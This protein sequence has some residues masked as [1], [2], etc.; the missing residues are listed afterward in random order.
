MVG[1]NLIRWH[2]SGVNTST[3]VVMQPVDVKT[4]AAAVVV[5]LL[6]KFVVPC[7][8]ALAPEAWSLLAIFVTTIIGA[9]PR[10]VDRHAK[11]L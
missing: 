3:L 2:A 8:A 7:P 5:G 6:I 11:V 10:A 9:L 1:R 4:A